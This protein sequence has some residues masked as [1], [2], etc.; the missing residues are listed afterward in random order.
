MPDASDDLMRFSEANRRRLYEQITERLFG[1]SAAGSLP[2]RSK[3][4]VI[5]FGGRWFAT[6]LDLN[7]PPTLPIE[8]RFRIARISVRPGRMGGIELYDV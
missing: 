3:L 8:M 4:Q 5:Y 2:D 7:E 6:W 1:S